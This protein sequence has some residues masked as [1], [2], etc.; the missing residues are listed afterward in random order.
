MMWP[1]SDFKFGNVSCTHT[2]SY[3]LT[4]TWYSRMDTALSWFQD[5]VNPAN[6]AMVYV[7]E[8]DRHGHAFSPDSEVVSLERL[9]YLC[10]RLVLQTHQ[11]AGGKNIRRIHR[12]K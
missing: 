12:F 9:N 10:D 4:E 11:L 7:E 1:G 6:L 5:K 3:N 2:H 8:P